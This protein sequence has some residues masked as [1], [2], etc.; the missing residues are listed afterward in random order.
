MLNLNFILGVLE[1]YCELQASGLVAPANRYYV[2]D[3]RQQIDFIE[4]LET[5]NAMVMAGSDELKLARTVL[6]QRS[7]LK[8]LEHEKAALD[9]R[10]AELEN[11]VLAKRVAELDRQ[12]TGMTAL[13]DNLQDQRD[14]QAVLVEKL[15]ADI[16][17]ALRGTKVDNLVRDGDGLTPFG[18]T[19]TAISVLTAA[20]CNLN[21]KDAKR[22]LAERD[23][24]VAR[25]GY[26]AGAVAFGGIGMA[27]IV[28]QE[29]DGFVLE[30][31]EGNN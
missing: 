22:H 1:D 16:T 30:K 31:L 20:L 9:K 29:A 10:I 14:T 13:V 21:D 3:V 7:V 17:T 23:V 24:R 19:E 11:G 5:D 6:S 28:E 2:S 12:L 15:K 18:K 26:V 25:Q 8:R 4:S 27:A